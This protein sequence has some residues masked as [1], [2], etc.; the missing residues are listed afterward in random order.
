[1]TGSNCT[2]VL[3]Y[4]PGCCR[5][6]CGCRQPCTSLSDSGLCMVCTFKAYVFDK[7][8]LASERVGLGVPP[9]ATEDFLWNGARSLIM[10]PPREP[11]PWLLGELVRAALRGKLVLVASASQQGAR[12][13]L[14][15]AR[16]QVAKIHGV[17]ARYPFN[18]KVR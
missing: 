6:T 12:A 10:V 7:T 2:Y 4:K 3:P 1:M 18:P 8:G 15:A 9:A 13:A 17:H 14:E 11:A 16:A 5:C